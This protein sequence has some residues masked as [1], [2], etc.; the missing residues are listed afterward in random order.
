MKKNNNNKNKIKKDILSKRFD[1]RMFVLLSMHE[2]VNI[3]A[4]IMQH[5]RDND[6][7]NV[8]VRCIGV[9]NEE[10]MSCAVYWRQQYNDGK[11]ADEGGHIEAVVD[12]HGNGIS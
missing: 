4:L 8:S 7:C 1:H 12:E 9:W 5:R 3:F 2:H 11:D 6:T 10:W